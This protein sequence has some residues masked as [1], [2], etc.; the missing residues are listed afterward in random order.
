METMESAINPISVLLVDDH[1]LF[2]SGKRS[3]LQ[4]H[5]DFAVVG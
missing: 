4:R 3:V 2:R 1:T 5:P